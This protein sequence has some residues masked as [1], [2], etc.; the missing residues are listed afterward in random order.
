MYWRES[1]GDQS[2]SLIFRLFFFRIKLHDKNFFYTLNCRTKTIDAT[3]AMENT[4]NNDSA[5][6]AGTVPVDAQE[7]HPDAGAGG[8]SPTN[9]GED[10]PPPQI[11]TQIPPRQAPHHSQAIFSQLRVFPP[12]Q[13]YT[14][15][16]SQMLSQPAYTTGQPIQTGSQPPL[17]A[18]QVYSQP[19][20]HMPSHYSGLLPSQLPLSFRYGEAATVPQSGGVQQL[21]MHVHPGNAP[22]PMVNTD[23]QRLVAQLL[24]NGAGNGTLSQEVIQLL[25]N[26]SAL[27]V[28]VPDGRSVGGGGQQP[29]STASRPPR[30]P[31]TEAVVGD[32]NDAARREPTEP[33]PVTVGASSAPLGY[34]AQVLQGMK[35]VHLQGD[36]KYGAECHAAAL[37]MGCCLFIAK[38]DG[39][40][41]GWFADSV[42]NRKIPYWKHV[43]DYGPL[44]LL[45]ST[46]D[47]GTVVS[48]KPVVRLGS[49]R[50]RALGMLGRWSTSGKVK[51]VAVHALKV[52]GNL[53]RR[54]LHWLRAYPKEARPFAM[55]VYDQYDLAEGLEVKEEGGEHFMKTRSE[56]VPREKPF[57]R[58]DLPREQKRLGVKFARGTH[59]KIVQNSREKAFRTILDDFAFPL[60][61]LVVDNDGGAPRAAPSANNEP[62]PEP[63]YGYS[64]GE[65]TSEADYSNT[66][67]LK[68][69]L[70]TLIGQLV[71]AKTAEDVAERKKIYK[72]NMKKFVEVRGR[73]ARFQVTMRFRCTV[74]PKS[75]DAQRAQRSV[76]S[77]RGRDGRAIQRRRLN[78]NEEDNGDDTISSSRGDI[79]RRRFSESIATALDKGV[80]GE[81]GANVDLIAQNIP[82]MP[83]GPVVGHTRSVNLHDL[84][85]K[86]L[87][88]YS[89]VETPDVFLGA[90]KNGLRAVHCLALSLSGVLREAMGDHRLPLE[91]IAQ[92]GVSALKIPRESEAVSLFDVIDPHSVPVFRGDTEHKCFNID[93][94]SYVFDVLKN[95]YDKGEL[96]TGSAGSHSTEVGANDDIPGI[97]DEVSLSLDI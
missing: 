48:K 82:K 30:P 87:A 74:R 80:L 32:S 47:S 19:L 81:D 43:K 22:N 9:L 66:A 68:I 83:E 96:T 8:Q 45:L 60:R 18:H 40:G 65:D 26:A 44:E 78:G 67:L 84:A 61:K 20:R 2:A 16:H 33:T 90:S 29:R 6:N 27:P 23:A 10:L 52:H 17:A 41:A 5:P 89:R 53:D 12:S 35:Y 38:H 14:P 64:Y 59:G 58:D 76:S 51:K 31:A 36:Y 57:Y 72:A 71:D 37:A 95:I 92:K 94:S 62:T 39:L 11:Q 97:G 28:S 1:V 85:M 21:G 50:G 54:D 15:G 46:C 3:T 75:T 55:R 4:N 42:L 63:E 34:A 77:S 56:S 93:Y 70:T 24:A 69:P 25:L 79:Q 88:N 13:P 49:K 73:W 86:L 7:N 91:I